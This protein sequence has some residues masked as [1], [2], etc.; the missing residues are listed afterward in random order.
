MFRVMR[1]GKLARAGQEEI[2]QTRKPEPQGRG[3]QQHRPDLLLDP[4]EFAV[5]AVRP[6][7]RRRTPRVDFAGRVYAPVV[8]RHRDV[9]QER[10]DPGEI[11]IDHSADAVSIEQHVI[12]EQIGVDRTARQIERAVER[13]EFELGCEQLAAPFV[14]ERRHF[15]RR[16]APPLR[17][18][19]ILELSVVASSGKMHVGKDGTDLLAVARLWRAHRGA[20]EAGDETGG[21]AVQG[22]EIPVAAVGDRR[23][24]RYAVTRKMRHEVQVEGKLHCTEPLEKREHEAAVQSGDEVIRVFDPRSDALQIDQLADSVAFQPGRKFLG[25]DTREDGHDARVVADA[26]ASVR[27][28]GSP[29]AGPARRDRGSRSS[30]PGRRPGPRSGST[31][32]PKAW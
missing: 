17:P 31:P 5:P 16:L 15:T 10:V 32:G 8:D 1:L 23:G 14:E 30:N 18:P 9:E 12:A 4:G 2:V 19:W 6:H 24:A 3:A 27:T 11:K 26:G 29:K 28:G 20:G 25:G 21:L 7:E 13:L 22:S